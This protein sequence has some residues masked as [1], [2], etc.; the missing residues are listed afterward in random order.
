MYM[1]TDSAARET[2]EKAEDL[3]KIPNILSVEVEHVHYSIPV[4]FFIKS[5][6]VEIQEA[7]EFLVKTSED[8]PIRALS[9]A[10]FVG[11]FPVTEFSRVDKN[12]YRFV[13]PAPELEKLKPGA[14]ISMGWAGVKLAKKMTTNFQLQNQH[15]VNR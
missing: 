4:Q 1:S 8:F 9:P 15:E 2:R 6:A 13:V 5:R 12:I 3:W 14:S 11:D 10:L 7:I